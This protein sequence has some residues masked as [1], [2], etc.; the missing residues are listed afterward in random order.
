MFLPRTVFNPDLPIAN[1]RE[2]AMHLLQTS[3]APNIFHPR[4]VYDGKRLLY[5][6][7][8]LNLPGGGGAA[9]F[10]VRLGNDPNAPVGS[11][12][13]FE[14]II[15]KTASEIIRPRADSA[16][17]TSLDLIVPSQ[18]LNRLITATGQTV[19]RKAATAMNLLQL[20]IRQSSNQN[21]PTNNGRAYFSPAGKRSLPGTGVE[22]WRGFF[23]SVRPTI[24]RMIVTIDT[25]MAAVYES[26]PLLDVAMSVLNVRS[27]R[28]LAL[29]DD[30]DPNFRKLQN[31]F[32]NRL[33]KTKTTGDK[34]KTIHA[35]EK[36][37]IGR[38]M[39]SKDGRETSIQATLPILLGPC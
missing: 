31:H 14:V 30:R 38:Y 17:S 34:T 33:I 28:D 7:H 25:S 36:G 29:Q 1:K 37:P 3:I 35:I 6:S 20:L 27:T 16:F 21:N 10:T 12:G 8:T 13:V 23:Q 39:F 4:G 18:D 24:G 19:D 15:T 32:K 2:R 22:L 9:R 11:P 26:G 5:L